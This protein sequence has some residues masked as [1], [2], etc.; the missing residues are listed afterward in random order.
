MALKNKMILMSLTIGNKRL[1]ENSRFRR[2]GQTIL[3]SCLSK[4]TQVMH[5]AFSL[6]NEWV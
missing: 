3:D 6:Q 1:L 2:R 4:W 5:P